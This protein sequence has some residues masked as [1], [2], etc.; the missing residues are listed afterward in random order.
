LV[1][2]GGSAAT[3]DTFDSAVYLLDLDARQWHAVRSEGLCYA[4]PARR[5]HAACVIKDSLYVYGG[6][7]SRTAYANTSLLRLHLTLVNP[8][9]T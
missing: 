6:K 2:Y 5:D 7:V 8:K 1:V 4:P 3:D 9:V